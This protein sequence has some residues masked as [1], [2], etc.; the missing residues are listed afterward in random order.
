M[1]LLLNQYTVDLL[2]QEWLKRGKPE[3]GFDK[4]LE[5]CVDIYEWVEK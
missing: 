2:R 4:W 1:K 5:D 3:S